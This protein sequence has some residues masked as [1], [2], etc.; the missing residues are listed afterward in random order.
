[1]SLT[2]KDLEEYKRI[3][4]KE[5]WEEISDKDALVQANALLSFVKTATF[6]NDKG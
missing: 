1:M 3:Y 6:P 2:E 4:F 5:Y